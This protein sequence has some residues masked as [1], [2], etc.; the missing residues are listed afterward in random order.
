MSRPEGFVPC[1][2]PILEGPGANEPI[3]FYVPNLVYLVHR[4]GGMEVLPDSSWGVTD[5]KG[6]Y[7]ERIVEVQSFK[8]ESGWVLTVSHWRDDDRF[9]DV[10][11]GVPE[12]SHLGDWEV[13]HV[14]SED[15]MVPTHELRLAFA[16]DCHKT[17][18]LKLADLNRDP[19]VVCDHLN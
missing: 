1:N 18:G 12:K 8:T 14:M 13:L 7:G 5:L 6:K 16:L 4:L 3:P 11:F 10:L 17:V 2:D 19:Y 15:M 9:L